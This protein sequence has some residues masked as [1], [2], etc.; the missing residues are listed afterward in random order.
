V[1]PHLECALVLFCAG[2]D[3]I[4]DLRT[5]RADQGLRKLIGFKL[6]SPTQLKEFLYR[7]HQDTEG[8]PLSPAQDA[9]LSQAG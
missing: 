3:C 1:R 2:G 4:E 6:S 5:L 8:N 9:E 7:F